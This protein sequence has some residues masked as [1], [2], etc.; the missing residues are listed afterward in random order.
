[1]GE[2]GFQSWTHSVCDPGLVSYPSIGL[3][4]GSCTGPSETSP[5]PAVGRADKC[6]TRSQPKGQEVISH[7]PEGF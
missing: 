1:M 2:L 5:G 7:V 4:Y 6:Y 3:S